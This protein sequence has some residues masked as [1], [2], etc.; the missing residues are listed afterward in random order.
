MAVHSVAFH[1]KRS[2]LVLAGTIRYDV[3]ATEG[4]FVSTD[5]AKTFRQIP[6]DIP[7]VNI[8]SITFTAAEATSAY[9]G[10]MGTGIFRIELGEKP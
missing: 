4:L 10:F 3:R 8:T 2:R 5:S 7:K 6:M 9:I 1:P